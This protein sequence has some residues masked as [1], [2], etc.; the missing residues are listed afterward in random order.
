MI[1]AEY[2]LH[3]ARSVLAADDEARRQGFDPL[4]VGFDTTPLSGPGEDFVAALTDHGGTEFTAA[5][6][7]VGLDL[8]PD[9]FQPPSAST[10]TSPCATPTARRPGSS[11]PSAC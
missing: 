2:A 11:T 8:F 6:G 1:E 10:R 7:Y 3:M 9:V 4:R 5:L